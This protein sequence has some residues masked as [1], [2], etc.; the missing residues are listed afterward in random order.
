MHVL[1]KIQTSH[2]SAVTIPDPITDLFVPSWNVAIEPGQEEMIVVNGTVQQVDAYMEANYPG[3]SA[4]WANFTSNCS[5]DSAIFWCN[6]TDQPKI[7]DS[8]SDI[9]LGAEIVAYQCGMNGYDLTVSGQAFLF[10]DYS[11]IVGQ[12]NCDD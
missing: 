11:V 8:F 3:W 5:D 12:S 6:D 7:L 9:A 2:L 4:K 10:G 1:D